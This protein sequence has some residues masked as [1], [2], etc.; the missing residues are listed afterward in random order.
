[1]AL[2]AERVNLAY[3]GDCRSGVRWMIG[4]LVVILAM[5]IYFYVTDPRSRPFVLSAAA[6]IG[7]AIP[8]LVTGRGWLVPSEGTIVRQRLWVLRRRLNLSTVSKA[9]LVNNRGGGLLLGLR[10]PG[11]RRRYY[12]GILGFSDYGFWSASPELLRLL[13]DQLDR[14]TPAEARGDVPAQLREQADHVDA[15][16]DLTASPLA[17]RITFTVMNIAKGGGAV[18]GGSN[19]LP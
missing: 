14:W 9:E 17:S 18:G 4:T 12:V 13:A 8:V 1:M 10:R 7:L 19:L 2:T 3:K 15:G 16:G 5:A 6:L 11:H